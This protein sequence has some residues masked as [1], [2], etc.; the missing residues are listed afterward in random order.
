MIQRRKPHSPTIGRRLWCGLPHITRSRHPYRDVTV[1][2]ADV[3][4]DLQ[5]AAELMRS[6]GVRFRAVP[7]N[8]DVGDADTRVSQSPTSGWRAGG[9]IS[10]WDPRGCRGCS[11]VRLDAMLLG[12]RNCEEAAQA[13]WLDAVMADAADGNCPA[14]PPAFVVSRQSRRTGHRILVG[15]TGAAR[16]TIQLMRRHSVTWLRAVI[17]IGRMKLSAAAPVTGAGFSFWVGPSAVDAAEKR[18]GPF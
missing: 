1:D 6:L 18:L 10:A 9:T 2:G 4:E 17:C 7:G 12:S 16:L 5:H 8:H 13:A 3:E 15:E 14:S 11:L